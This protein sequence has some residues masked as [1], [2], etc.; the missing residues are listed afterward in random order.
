MVEEK[1]R[2]M[3]TFLNQLFGEA[4]FYPNSPSFCLGSAAQLPALTHLSFGEGIS[5]YKRAKPIILL[6]ACYHFGLK[7]GSAIR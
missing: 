5:A 7:M 3:M 1:A 6:V 4:R 2:C